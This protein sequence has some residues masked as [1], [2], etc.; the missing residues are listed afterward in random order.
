MVMSVGFVLTGGSAVYAT[1]APSPSPSG[2]AIPVAA[3]QT[4]TTVC[5]IGSGG[6]GAVYLTGLATT[7]SGYV[8]VDA[9]NPDWGKYIIYLNSKC[10]RTNRLSYPGGAH[11][12]QDVQVD[13][14]GNVW[15]ADSGD[16][17]PSNRPFI[18]LWKVPAGGGNITDYHFTYPDG[19]HQ[20]EAMV[21][22][23]DGRPIFV[24]QPSSGNGE[25]GLYEPPAGSLKSGT[26]VRMTSVGT[27]SPEHTG[28]PNKLSV[29]GNLLV[30]G[31]ANAPDGTKVVLRTFSDA[32][33]WT[34]SGGDVAA[35]I[36][37][38]KPVITQ[39]PNETQGEAIAFTSDGTDFLT[40]SDVNTATPILKYTPSTTPS[41]AAKKTKAATGPKKVGAIHAWF[42]RLSLEQL[43]LYL[44]LVA[45]LGLALICLGIF[46][47]M[48]HR[49]MQSVAA[50]SAS[51]ARPMGPRAD[52]ARTPV[53]A[54]GPTPGGYGA[55]SGPGGGYGAPSGPGGA[56]GVYGG[57]AR[58]SSSPPGG[59]NVYGAPSSGAPGGNV[60]GGRGGGNVYGGS[61]G[62]GGPVYGTPRDT[63]DRGGYDPYASGR[64]QGPNGS[65]GG[66]PA[67]GGSAGG[68]PTGGGSAG[69]R[70]SGGQYSGG[71]YGT[72][73]DPY[74]GAADFGRGPSAN[75]GRPP[76][77]PDE[78]GDYPS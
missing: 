5:Q 74:D 22:D 77:Y 15:V 9:A 32:Y 21:L 66:G 36:T 78:Y 55:P 76:A 40:V 34:V 8:A 58:P 51:R 20:A 65:A 70:G 4:P 57:S 10:T 30:T 61:G 43:Q 16:G 6:T 18:T 31:G 46:G 75:R 3:A 73:V 25:A 48:R 44:G 7:K 64:G 24:T 56:G 13:K 50:V 68:G 47:I 33:E 60:Y 59:G 12:P 52:Q 62:G 26:T 11:D 35:A 2:L 14:A 69:G 42:N 17:A 23:G 1:P 19:A 53:P 37:K 29:S 45:F 54:G 72:P 27:F 41:A 39:L 28:T 63:P 67:G 49:R 71:Q 38:T